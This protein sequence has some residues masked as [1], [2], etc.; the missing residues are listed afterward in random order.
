MSVQVIWQKTAE[1]QLD[2][3]VSE[4]VKLFGERVAAKFYWRV[5]DYDGL[6]INNPF[7][8]A[9]EPL[10]SER[11][12]EYRSLVVHEHYKLVYRI[13]GDRIHIADLWDTRREPATLSRRIRGK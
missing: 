6:L 2:M 9:L 4:G 3:V 1:R 11:R 13:D 10:L 5:K 8:G 7:M 12:T